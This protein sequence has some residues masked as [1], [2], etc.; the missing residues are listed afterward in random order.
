MRRS[1][2][3]RVRRTRIQRRHKERTGTFLPLGRSCSRRRGSL[4]TR[5]T[6]SE[7]KEC[8]RPT[9][10]GRFLPCAPLA[11]A[12]PSRVHRDRATFSLPF[13]FFFTRT[14]FFL[15][16]PS[17]S[18]FREMS[19]SPPPP[20]PFL[21]P[22]RKPASRCRK[23]RA[24]GE[25]KEKGNTAQPR[26]PPPPP[27]H[28]PRGERFVLHASLLLFRNLERV[29]VMPA[30]YLS[31]ASRKASPPSAKKAPPAAWGGAKGG[32]GAAWQSKVVAEVE[33]RRQKESW[34][35]KKA[36]VRDA[37]K[38]KRCRHDYSSAGKCPYGE[39]CAFLHRSDEARFPRAD[40]AP[41]VAAPLP[42]HRRLECV[43]C[44]EQEREDEPLR[45]FLPCGHRCVCASCAAATFA[46]ARARAQEVVPPASSAVP[47]TA[48]TT[49]VALCPYCRQ[50][51]EKAVP[52]YII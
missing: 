28:H 2:R 42:E 35:P 40:A 24:L 51:T 23:S 11:E 44:C 46:N 31:A 52:I 36:L 4:S 12:R 48:S 16:P 9:A 43:I 32:G 20:F 10:A 3:R 1:L 18:P 17:L 34:K 14:P 41:P 33:E 19:P 45:A 15:I 47:A 39:K 29:C 49:S 7:K 37:Y 8:E 26:T 25:G 5:G 30:D 50:P 27:P 21:L 6:A 13:L 38:T 22:L